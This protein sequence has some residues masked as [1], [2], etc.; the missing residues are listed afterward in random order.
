MKLTGR[1]AGRFHYYAD[2]RRDYFDHMT[3]EA[4]VPGRL[5]KKVWECRAG[6]RCEAWDCEVYSLHAARAKRVH[7]LK[8]DDWKKIETELM[9]TDLFKSGD[10]VLQSR[11]T[12][13]RKSK[14]D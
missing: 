10:D 1:G 5:G 11:T 14:W 13:R 9:Q 2:V 6:R 12:E 3:A 4:K 8:P 7:L